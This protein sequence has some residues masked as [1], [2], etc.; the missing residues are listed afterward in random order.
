MNF[1]KVNAG[2]KVSQNVLNDLIVDAIQDIKG[3]NITKI[4][5]REIDDS[6]TN[7]FIICN[8]DSATQIKAIAKNVSNRVKN[9]LGIAPSHHEGKDMANWVLVDYFNTVLHV[10]YPETRVFYDLE[11]LWSDGTITEYDDL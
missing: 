6:P 4:D 10:F 1:A 9:E 7:Y 5:L 2:P 3:S 11:D 8:G